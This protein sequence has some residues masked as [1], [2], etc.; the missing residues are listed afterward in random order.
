MWI[1]LRCVF[2]LCLCASKCFCVPAAGL[3]QQRAPDRPTDLKR[4]RRHSS[5]QRRRAATTPYTRDTRHDTRHTH[6]YSGTVQHATTTAHTHNHHI[7]IRVYTQLLQ[8]H[9][10]NISPHAIRKIRAI[11]LANE[12]THTTHHIHTTFTQIS[13]LLNGNY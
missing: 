3:F 4:S 7:A 12:H 9:A 1:L 11:P 13:G 8:P 6:A 5:I 2:V 10:S